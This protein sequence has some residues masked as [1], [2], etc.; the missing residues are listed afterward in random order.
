MTTPSFEGLPL[1]GADESFAT[2]LQESKGQPGAAVV[3]KRAQQFYVI[4]AGDLLQRAQEVSGGAVG[5]QIEI[6]QDL[7]ASPEPALDALGRLDLLPE[8]GTATAAMQA[9]KGLTVDGAFVCL[10][11]CEG[12]EES[13][14]CANSGR[15]ATCA[16]GHDWKRFVIS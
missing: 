9:A 15:P 12:G 7:L 5:R 4:H 14:P 8:A 11:V 10:W 13:W 6:V 2:I 1:F 3:L 16:K